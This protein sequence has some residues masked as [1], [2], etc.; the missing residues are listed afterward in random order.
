MFNPR[1]LFVLQNPQTISASR[2][3]VH[4]LGKVS[5]YMNYL[6]EWRTNLSCIQKAF[7]AVLGKFTS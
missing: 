3:H 4:T 6:C 5:F 1:G 7:A 2:V